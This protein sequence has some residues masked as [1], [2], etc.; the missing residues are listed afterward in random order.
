MK[1]ISHARYK[2][3]IKP[4]GE[5]TQPNKTALAGR[6]VNPPNKRNDG[7]TSDEGKVMDSL[8]EAYNAFVK[9]DRQHPNELQDFIDGIHECQSVLGL[10]ILRRDYPKGWPI[11]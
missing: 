6:D 4:V 10:R 9:L 2:P 11:K 1:D 8:V 3:D 5:G 7:L